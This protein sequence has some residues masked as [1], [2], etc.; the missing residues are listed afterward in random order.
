MAKTF[1]V[2]PMNMPLLETGALQ[3]DG[4]HQIL[5]SCPAAIPLRTFYRQV[6]FGVF[7]KTIAVC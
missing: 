5:P 7:C 1:S 4:N 2:V 3:M 6:T